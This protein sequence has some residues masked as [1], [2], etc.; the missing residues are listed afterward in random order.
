MTTVQTFLALGCVALIATGQLLFKLVGRMS[1]ARGLGDTQV[2]IVGGLALCL[3]GVA[4]IA[5][6]YLLRSA[7]LSKAYPWMALSFVLVA[8][9]S[10]FFFKESLSAAY[11][12][13]LM[14]IVAGV[15][16]IGRWA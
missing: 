7:E 12:F 16:L 4:T 5:W 13:G 2:L 3:Y 1:L 6:I 10:I 8:L 11:W 9:G 15:V 14:L